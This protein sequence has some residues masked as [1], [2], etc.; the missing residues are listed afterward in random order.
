M[1]KVMMKP[2]DV[3]MKSSPWPSGRML[4]LNAVGRSSIPGRVIPKI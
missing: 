1:R 3:M 4:A 2:C